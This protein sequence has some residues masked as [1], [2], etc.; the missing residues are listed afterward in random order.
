MGDNGGM[1][2]FCRIE[3][4]GGL[5]VHIAGRTITRFQTRKTGA[6]LAYLA[7]H[8]SRPHSREV[9]AE[10]LWP[11]KEPSAARNSLNQ[12]VSSLRRQ[13][14]P[15]GAE[16]GSVIA[17]DAHS[18]WINKANVETDVDEFRG[19]VSSIAGK[20]SFEGLL[21]AANLYRGDLL[22]GLYEEWVV[23][24][25]LN[26]AEQYFQCVRSL[27]LEFAEAGRWDDARNCVAAAIAIDPFDAGFRNLSMNLHQLAGRPAAAVREYEECRKVF[28]REGE[29]VPEL[30][31]QEYE[32]AKLANPGVEVAGAMHHSAGEIFSHVE[33]RVDRVVPQTLSVPRYFTPFVG[34]DEELRHVANWAESTELGLLT[35]LGTGG[36]GKTRLASHAALELAEMGH[37]VFWVNLASLEDA[38]QILLE[39]AHAVCGTEIQSDAVLTLREALTRLERPSIFLDNL[40]HLSEHAAPTCTELLSLMRSGHIVA[41]SRRRVGIDAERILQV[42]PLPVPEDGPVTSLSQNPSISLFV[43]RAQTVK[44]DFQL[45]EKSAPSIANLCRRLEGL[46]LAL[47]LA[48]SWA[49]TLTPAQMLERVS[50]RMEFLETNRRD[51]SDR[52]RS[53]RAVIDGSFEMLSKGSRELLRRASVFRDGWGREAAQAIAPSDEIDASLEELSDCSV[54]YTAYV[55]DEARFYMLETISDYASRLLS[56]DEHAEVAE[57]HARYFLDFVRR[58]EQMFSGE[59]ARQLDPDYRNAV[60][61]LRHFMATENWPCALELGELLGGYWEFRGRLSEGLDHL[62]RLEQAAQ[63]GEHD[64]KLAQVRIRIATLAWEQGLFE[65]AKTA[66]SKALESLRSSD[67]A[68]LGVAALFQLQ[69]ECHRSGR[70]EECREILKEAIGIGER[71]R[72]P[73]IISTALRRSGNASIELGDWDRALREYEDSLEVA[74]SSGQAELIAPALTNL[75]YLG[76]LFGRL[77]AARIW[78][79][80]AESANETAGRTDVR[81]DCMVNRINLERL[82]GEFHAAFKIAAEIFSAEFEGWTFKWEPF[83]AMGMLCHDA[84]MPAEATVLLGYALHSL[85]QNY[86]DCEH[87]MLREVR[88]YLDASE[89]QLGER[90]FLDRLGLGRTMDFE[91]VRRF[92]RSVVLARTRL[93]EPAPVD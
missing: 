85:E 79:D 65:T 8:Q 81:L 63:A 25:R 21:R 17:S 59:G 49:R 32:R 13:V 41:T 74:R 18:L 7:L 88:R 62:L 93:A 60:A 89:S 87:M 73:Y 26:L 9:L 64:V 47:E 22:F 86:A 61:A 12:A 52:H 48:A 19:L 71:L 11:N 39:V 84:G 53:I 57:L 43:S 54:V 36:C 77:E 66:I 27:T 15:P 69:K 33:G 20:R 4:L 55:G 46:P 90:R 2:A 70:Y 51:I 56:A 3:M 38:N 28:E 76:C 6:L 40:E 83:A 82:S 42:A 1:R 78:L 10:L 37:T 68:D 44:Q 5:R 29:P 16:V 45:T 34:R 92:A 58:S 24:E 30:L 31:Q 72:S 35:I 75:G 23:P 14:H 80:E 91:E 67:R 50:D